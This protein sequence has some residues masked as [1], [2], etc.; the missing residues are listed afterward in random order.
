[1]FSNGAAIPGV[2]R[3]FFV[4]FL[5]TALLQ[6]GTAAAQNAG[7]QQ[8]ETL[9]QTGSQSPIPEM[10]IGGGDLLE[11]SVFGTDFVK[12][13]RVSG[14]GEISLPLVGPLKVSGLSIRDA[15]QTVARELSQRGYFN[16]PQVSVFDREYTT[17][18]ISVLGEVQKPGIYP[19]PGDR[20]LFDAISAAGG[21]TARAG[22]Q[23][24]ITHRGRPDRPDVVQFSYD[25]NAIE[26]SNPRV[27]PGD[28]VV[29]A[30]AGIV[31]VVGDVREPKG[32]VMENSRMTVLQAIAM[33]Q[34]AN[35]TAALDSARLIRKSADG[36]H[37]TPIPLKKILAAKAS[38]PTLQAED[39]LFL[40]TSTAK[41]AG[42]RSIEA[43]I[44][45]A[46]GVA[47]YHPY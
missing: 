35:P 40:P 27:S 6:V 47:I 34:G 15:E 29:V 21:T 33:A 3:R 43:I 17:Q 28:T 38:D 14:T 37:E 22:S 36:P 30:K 25:A 26:R 41:S 20:N 39:I 18:A 16:D 9:S 31:Y 7:S 2:L 32:I 11:V 45:A 10:L 24:S 19:L 4:C 12:Q 44:Q 1:M 46:T 5:L 23:V 42:R 13:V 8:S